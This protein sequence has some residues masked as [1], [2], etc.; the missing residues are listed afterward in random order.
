MG[1][2]RTSKQ[3]TMTLAVAAL[4]MNA[5]AC[6]LQ[7]EQILEAQP[8]SQFE[9]SILTLPPDIQT[10]EGGT[11]MNI[12]ISIGLFD[13]LFG[14]FEGDISVGELLLASPGFNF[15]GIPALNTGV[16]CVV[17][18]E[19]DPGGGTFE[20]NIWANTATFDVDLNALALLGNPAVAALLQGGGFATSFALT[21]TVPFSLGDMLGMLTGSGDLE[22]TQELDQDFE[23]TVQIPPNPPTNIAGHIGG[24]IALAS[25]DAF[26]SSPLLQ[27]CIDLLEE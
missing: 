15:F 1:V 23:I 20:A 25:T 17:P 19:V 6:H 3:L 24:Q 22:I 4:A 5:V 12:D 14:S 18:D 10:I 7:L 8:G 9:I 11:V 13:L 21:S 16:I 2:M 26:P 27:A